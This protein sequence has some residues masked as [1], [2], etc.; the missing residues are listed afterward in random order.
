MVKIGFR[1]HI[2]L[3]AKEFNE[4]KTIY[5][6]DRTNE[7]IQKL[8]DYIDTTNKEYS[9]HFE[10]LKEWLNKDQVAPS[11]VIKGKT[12]PRPEDDT[13]LEYLREKYHNVIC[14]CGKR[15][16]FVKFDGELIEETI[17]NAYY[18]CECGETA[19]EEITGETNKITYGKD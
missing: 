5:G 12:E 8:D 11:V 16:Q 17:P 9:S 1:K 19:Y 13:I 15:M 6:I 18:K 7:Y 3:T 14:T 4:L 2:K 10:T